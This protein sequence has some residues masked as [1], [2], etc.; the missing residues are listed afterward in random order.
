[1]KTIQKFIFERLKL[2]KDTETYD[3]EIISNYFKYDGL[4]S[5]D[6]NALKYIYPCLDKKYIKDNPCSPEELKFDVKA[7]A[8]PNV[9]KLLFI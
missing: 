4:Y 2:N 1:M 7:N 9:S 5:M 6:A 8:S 3:F